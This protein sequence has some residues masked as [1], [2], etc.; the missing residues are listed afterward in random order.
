MLVMSNICLKNIGGIMSV[1]IL[2][3]TETGNSESLAN[4]AFEVLKKNGIDSE[5]LNMEDVSLNDLKGYK[6][7]LIITSTW[8]EGDAPSNAADLLEELNSEQSSPLT[9]LSYAVFGIGESIYDNFCQAAI[10][11]DE[12]LYKLGGERLEEV[13]KSEDDNEANLDKWIN[14]L[15]TK[16][17]S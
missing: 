13:Q 4:Q 5:V 12:I 2:Y 7:V 9:E 10:D 1:K 16:L 11:F 3:G 8:G 6:N 15:I 14:C 17:K